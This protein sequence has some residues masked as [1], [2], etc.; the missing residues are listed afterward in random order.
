VKVLQ[1]RMD[2]SEWEPLDEAARLEV[3]AAFATALAAPEAGPEVA[4]QHVWAE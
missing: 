4:F 3:E 1:E 2:P